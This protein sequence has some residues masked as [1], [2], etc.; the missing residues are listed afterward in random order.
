MLNEFDTFRRSS[1]AKLLAQARKDA[2]QRNQNSSDDDESTLTIAPSV[3]WSQGIK[4]DTEAYPTFKES[5]FWD[6]WNR[7]FKSKAHLHGVSDV[8]DGNYTPLPGIE[9]ANFELKKT[10]VY[11]VFLGK[12]ELNEA[13]NIV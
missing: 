6:K 13:A 5:R 1:P 9:T 7:E 3:P 2:Q 4:R 8:L 12:I 10:F 11:A